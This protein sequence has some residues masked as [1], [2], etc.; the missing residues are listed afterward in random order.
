MEDEFAKFYKECSEAPGAEESEKHGN[1]EVRNDSAEGEFKSEKRTTEDEKDKAETILAGQKLEDNKNVEITKE[2]VS[3]SEGANADKM[4]EDQKKS[5]HT[6]YE[7]DTCI[8]TNPETKQEYVWSTDINQWVP[9]GYKP[10]FDGSTYKYTDAD[11][12]TF[13]W[14]VQKSVWE[15]EDNDNKAGPSSSQ[16]QHGFDGENHTYT[17]P[18]DNTVYIWDREKNAWFPKVDE[19][20]MARYQMSY[21]FVDNTTKEEPPTEEKKPEKRKASEP[22]WFEMDDQHN[23]KVYV[24]NLPPEITEQEFIDFMQKCGLIQKDIKTNKFK[25]KLYREPDG[26]LK[27]DALCDYIKIES[28]DL[29]LKVLDGYDIKGK[30]VKIQRAKFQMKGDYNPALKP[31]KKRKK[32]KEQEKKVQQKLLDWRPDKLRGER[33]KHERTVVIKN[34]FDPVIFDENVELILEYTEDIRSE[35]QKCGAVRKVYYTIF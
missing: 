13:R 23:T 17:D 8:Y 35:A 11:G 10:E 1:S 24:S 4:A 19:D 31:K 32:E 20:F 9:R 16:A 18:K 22:S 15:K 33:E 7:G 12:V 14:N 30:K 21:G 25:I 34:L 28:V 5:E 27:G 2:N 29:T 3:G 6:R 26:T